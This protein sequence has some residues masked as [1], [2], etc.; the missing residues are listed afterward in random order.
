M[1]KVIAFLLLAI[2]LSGCAS[3][4]FVKKGLEMENA[5]LYSDAANMYYNSL[6]KNI[7]NVDAKLGLQRTGQLV[8]DDYID[9][10]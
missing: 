2:V 3:K 5:G 4:R 8:L 10:F 9:E 1:K 7:N 6:L